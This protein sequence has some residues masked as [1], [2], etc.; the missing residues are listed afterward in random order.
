MKFGAVLPTCEIGNDPTALRDFAQAAE[1]LGYDHLLLY[2]HVLGAEHRDREP[3]LEGP[4]DENDAFHE[5]MTLFAYLAAVTSRIELA[6]GVLIL[7][8]RQTVLVA[9]Q[10]AELALLSEGRF[11]LGV[12]SG[13]SPVEYRALGIPFEDRGPR[14]EAQ[15]EL[16]R[17]LWSEPVLDH[18][19]D[20]H[21]IDRA[22]LLPRP[23]APIPIWF[24]GMGSRPIRRA[25]RLGD[26]FT[27]G[28]THESIRA[29]ALLLR[30]ELV[31]QGR[32]DAPFGCETQIGYGHGP[33]IWHKALARWEDVGL[34]HFSVRTMST[35]SSW[36]REP[37]P[38]L[39][40]VADHIAG[41]ERFVSELR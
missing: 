19:D 16:M 13:W 17:Q 30:E 6:T 36:S 38:G 22:G 14:L 27:F 20:Y 5:P 40:T 1:E 34:T 37:D 15:V 25:A 26:G 7:P 21:R 10:A 9:K 12:G 2:D 39:T 18:E 31:K 28:G 4:Y 8:Q 3:A 23:A 41:L 24:G 32:A 35:G 33:E 11:R 29:R